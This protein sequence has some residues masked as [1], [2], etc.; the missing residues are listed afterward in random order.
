MS[1]DQ[2]I[3]GLFEWFARESRLISEQANEPKRR[4]RFAHLAL[5]WAIMAVEYRE[6]S[7]RPS[8]EG[9]LRHP[10]RWQPLVPIVTAVTP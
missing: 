9:F 6:R 7:A 10:S 2:D 3:P 5:Q 8:R 4:E 1:Y